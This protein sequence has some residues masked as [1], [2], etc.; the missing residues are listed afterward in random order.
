[1]FKF[2]LYMKLHLPFSSVMLAGIFM[3]NSAPLHAQEPGDLIIQWNQLTLKVAKKAGQNSN[4]ATHTAAIEAIAVYDAV[5]SIKYFGTPYHYF[6]KTVGPASAEAA[7]VQAAHDVLANY[8]PAQKQ[9]IDSALTASLNGIKGAVE[10][11]QQVGAASAADIIALRANDGSSPLTTYADIKNPGVGAYRLTPGKFA[12]GVDVEW[13]TVKPFLLKD[14]KQF[15]PVTPP[16]I[17]SDEY[18]KAL[19]EVEELGANNSTKRS[20]DQTHIAQFYKQDAELTV[21][22]GL[23]A[24]AKSHHTSLEDNALIFALV[25][26]AEADA[27]IEIWGGKYT[28]LRWRPVTALNATADGTIKDYTKWTPLINTP[29]HPSYPSGHSATVTA[30]YEVLKHFFGDKNELELTTTTA[31]EGPRKLTSL[32][33]LE[34]ENGYSRIYGGIHFQFENTAAQDVGRKIAAYVLTT[35]PKKLK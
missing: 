8:F 2:L 24:L 6:K 14:A 12:P 20:E 13:G 22:D 32:S 11:G 25:D 5:N 10:A 21:N 30:G 7:A 35:G 19:K 17:G 34:W 4:L 18:N 28:Y 26:I 27:R 29:P 1:V 23:R 3:L 31:G 33:T 9:F 15:F 16:V